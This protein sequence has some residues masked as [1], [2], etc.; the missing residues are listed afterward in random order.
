MRSFASAVIAAGLAAGL[1]HPSIARANDVRW[2]LALFGSPAFRVAGESLA[3][4]VNEN[5]DGSFTITVHNGTLA[6]AREILDNLS[7]GAFQ[8]GYVVSSYHP[9]KNPLMSV[10]DLPFLP[11]K[12]MEQRV[13]VAEALFDNEH[14]RK[15]FAKWNTVPVMAV[16]QPN[17]EI[18]GK[19]DRPSSLEAFDG[20]RMKAT[21]GIGDAL[22]RFG[23]RTV[24][25][26][27]AEQ[28]NALQTGVIDAVAATPS[29]HGGWKLYEH[30]TWY[31]VGM[32][33][34][35]AHV[36]IVA[37]RD[38]YDAL[39]DEHKALLAEAV[40]HAYAKTIE[41][42]SAAAEKYRPTFAE[43]ELER[44]DISEVMIARLRE[45]A[46][47]P[48]WEAYIADVESKGQPGREVFDFVMT[49]A[50]KAK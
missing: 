24:A 12:T 30:S 15:E 26:T 50:E 22:G 19:G 46:A 36:S 44:V 6:P 40:E 1:S 5:G 45:E 2:D 29:A 7:F 31:T 25:M 20:M 35:T 17:Y 41:A 13:R 14:I 9:G 48:V 16:V 42:Q 27:G 47:K 10:L 21:S 11:I 23:A 33:A 34:G 28:Y 8:L 3:D 49:E 32:D 39:S 38:A 37:N 4:Y 43:Y 18:M